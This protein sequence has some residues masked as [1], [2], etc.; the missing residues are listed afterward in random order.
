MTAKFVLKD[1]KANQAVLQG[2]THSVS[3]Y[4]V[5]TNNYATVVASQN[6]EQRTV[7]EVGDEIFVRLQLYVSQHRSEPASS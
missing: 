1:I 2:T 4:D 5:L 7:Q 3:S 6:A